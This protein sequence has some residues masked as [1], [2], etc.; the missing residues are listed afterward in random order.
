M[1]SGVEPLLW[2]DE[3]MRISHDSRGEASFVSDSRGQV[4][5]PVQIA[6]RVR[7]F[8]GTGLTGTITDFSSGGIRVEMRHPLPECSL[9]I[10]AFAGLSPRTA[11]VVW[12][13]EHEAGLAFAEALH[14]AVAAHIISKWR[15][16]RRPLC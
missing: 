11:R 13:N 9:V 7:P 14:P 4:R 6:V 16:R 1:Q 8:L 5:W 10:V 12:R 15:D 3:E 2:W